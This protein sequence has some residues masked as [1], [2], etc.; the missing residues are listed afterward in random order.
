[1]K[2][3]ESLEKKR[4]YAREYLKNEKNRKRHLKL[5]I[6]R[7]KTKEGRKKYNAYA[8]AYYHRT[9]NPQK[10]KKCSN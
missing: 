10:N 2:K 1:M 4:K 6:A 3:E 7:R 5:Q 8:L 9:K